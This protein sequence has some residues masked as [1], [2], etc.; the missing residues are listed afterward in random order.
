M[1][2]RIQGLD[3]PTFFNQVFDLLTTSPGNLAY[4]IILAFS[5]VGALQVVISHWRSSGFP[6]GRRT[7]IGLG[8]L[9][10]AQLS[11]FASTILAW[12]NVLDAHIFIPPVDRVV[13]LFSLVIILWIWAFPE[14]SRLADAATFLL[15]LLVGTGLVLSLIWWGNNSQ[16]IDYNNSWPDSISSTLGIILSLGGIILVMI[17]RPNGW[18]V[19]AGMLALIGAG[20]TFQVL[21]SSGGDYPGVLRLA[22]I[23]A[24][25]LLLTLP[26]RFPISEQ[27]YVSPDGASR[28][29]AASQPL[30]RTRPRYSGDPKVMQA[31]LELAAENTPEKACKESTRMVSQ[32]MLADLCLLVSLQGEG[33]IVISCG[34][35]LIRE[36]AIEGFTIE[37][38]LSPVMASALRRNRPLR[39]PASSTSPDIQSLSQALNMA[40]V[41]HLLVVPFK[42]T[43]EETSS[44]GMILLS[45]YSNRSWTQEDQTNLLGLTS[46]IGRI[47]H[48]THQ[49]NDY[50]NEVERTQQTL[51][52]TRRRLEQLDQDNEKLRSELA[53]SQEQISFTSARAESLAAMFANQDTMQTGE[54][55]GPRLTALETENRQLK[56][57]LASGT[58]PNSSS[59]APSSEGKS[60]SPAAQERLNEMT[61]IAQDLRQPMSSIVGYT[62]LL[63]GES[64]G[65][66]GAMQRKFLERIK[67]SIERMNGLVDDFANMTARERLALAPVSV[68]LNQVIDEAIAQCA[69]NL[70]D[71]NIALRVDLPDQLPEMRADHDALHQIL[72]HLL[73]NAGVATP[74]DGD[75]SLSVR[76]ETQEHEPGYALLQIADSGDGIPLED[77]PRVFSRLYRSENPNIKGVGDNGIGLSIVKTLVEAHGGRIWV[78]SDPGHGATYSVLLPLGTDKDRGGMM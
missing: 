12:Q 25:P 27:K 1:Y 17:R 31:F 74:S 65:I 78:D 22:Q 37:T 49:V 48:H 11:L 28:A 24:F 44:M 14:T 67:S 26:Q 23:T 72:F 71:K 9:L 75:I 38:R 45:P 35:D 43:G 6:Q 69:S 62:D 8:L 36:I 2:P 63:L 30:I 68:N 60:T 34:Y 73:Q 50:G 13:S 51:E 55:I 10:L 41:G 20:Y 52:T 42:S 39:L 64:I 21:A 53:Y 47:L 77:L 5:I 3:M 46:A 58:T 54:G 76:I 59:L 61:S 19:G 32:L 33:P 7:S 57:A 66:L 4:H 40:R 15:I 18:G 56:E 16:G 70:R 29:T